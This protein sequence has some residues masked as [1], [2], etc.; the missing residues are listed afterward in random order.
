MTVHN[1]V[2]GP[3]RVL[4]SGSGHCIQRGRGFVRL[5]EKPGGDRVGPLY[6]RNALRLPSQPRAHAVPGSE[7][8]LGRGKEPALSGNR[9]FML[10]SLEV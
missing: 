4:C 3:W 6:V 1:P 7:E 9:L 8:T 5:G 10:S 2:L